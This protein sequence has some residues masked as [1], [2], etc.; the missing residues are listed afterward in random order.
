VLCAGSDNYFY[1]SG[2]S[3]QLFRMSPE[4]D[5]EWLART[6]PCR[7]GKAYVT[8]ASSLIPSRSGRLYGGT[9]DGYL[10]SLNLPAAELVSH[11][12]GNDIPDLHAL[13][14]GADGAIYGIA[15][16]GKWVSHL[17][18]FRPHHAE[19]TDLG[20]FESHGHYPWTGF[21]V[22]SLVA[23]REGQLYAGEADRFGHLFIYHP[24]SG[25]G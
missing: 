14:E 4:G 10:F 2:A 20:L 7:K 13:A 11:G 19:W 18:R 9:E 24:P 23:G 8:R 25:P 12:R 16:R 6:L 22:G 17:V 1:G 3:G 21:N 15:G 5:M